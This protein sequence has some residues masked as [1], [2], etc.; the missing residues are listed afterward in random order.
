VNTRDVEL[1]GRTVRMRGNAGGSWPPKNDT[2]KGP[3]CCIGEYAM[4]S[5]TERA[6]RGAKTRKPTSHRKARGMDKPIEGK[7]GWANGRVNP[8]EINRRR[9]RGRGE[10]WWAR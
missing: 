7:T 5:K 1:K 10:R 2:L 6:V 3:H 9:G 4:S 8:G